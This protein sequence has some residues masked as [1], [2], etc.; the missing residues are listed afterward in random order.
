MLT[1]KV[2]CGHS[3]QVWLDDPDEEEF[4]DDEN[5]IEDNYEGVSDPDDY[6]HLQDTIV[7][8]PEE[9]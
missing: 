1:H 7:E 3:R 8:D 9:H 4:F 2:V 5:Q 6:D